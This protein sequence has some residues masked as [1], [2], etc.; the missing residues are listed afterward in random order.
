MILP[1]RRGEAG[2]ARR[3][4]HRLDRARHRGREGGHNLPLTRRRGPVVEE[5][6][7]QMLDVVMVDDVQYCVAASPPI[8]RRGARRW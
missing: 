3:R 2:H 1:L 6:R 4:L 8:G 5:D 7:S